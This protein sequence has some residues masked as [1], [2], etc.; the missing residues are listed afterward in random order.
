MCLLDGRRI[1]MSYDEAFSVLGNFRA[2]Q[3]YGVEGEGFLR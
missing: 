3:I 2:S 1:F